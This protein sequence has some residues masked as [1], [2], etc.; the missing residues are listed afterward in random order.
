MTITL[1]AVCTIDLYT[2]I[3]N[4]KNKIKKKIICSIVYLAQEVK[5]YCLIGPWVV[6]NNSITGEFTY[7]SYPLKKVH[8]FI[9]VV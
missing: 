2:T 3:K 4:S 1:K 8:T 6:I 9:F 5:W 7:N